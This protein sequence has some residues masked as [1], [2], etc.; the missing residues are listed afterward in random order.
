MKRVARLKTALDKL[1]CFGL[2]EVGVNRGPLR[3]EMG[4]AF[5]A[6]IAK[7]PGDLAADPLRDPRTADGAPLRRSLR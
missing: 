6:S 5:E 4:A 2:G 7:H 3:R 1:A